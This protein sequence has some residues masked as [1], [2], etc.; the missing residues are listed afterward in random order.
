MDG[1]AKSTQLNLDVKNI[2]AGSHFEPCS[3]KV[4]YMATYDHLMILA[5]LDFDMV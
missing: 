3:S 2:F 5:S 1:V 4:P